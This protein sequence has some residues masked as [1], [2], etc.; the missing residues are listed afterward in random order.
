MTIKKFFHALIRNRVTERHARKVC[1]Q[2][3]II[4]VTPTQTITA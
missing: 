4:R 3:E 1:T 2:R